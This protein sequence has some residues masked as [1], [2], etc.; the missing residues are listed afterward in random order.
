M[1]EKCEVN[2]GHADMVIETGR[3]A[4]Q[5][6]G[7]V[8]VQ[9]GGT[10]VLATVCSSDPREGINFFPLTVDYREKQYA[11]GKIPGNFFRREAR[12]SEKEILTCR[13]IDRPV[14]PLFPKG[15]KDEVQIMLAVISADK[16]NDPAI[17]A[18][19]GAMAALLLSDLPFTTPLAAVRVGRM[20]GK[21]VVNP[22]LDDL[23]TSELDLIIAGSADGIVMVEGGATGVP[24]DVVVDALAFGHDHVKTII[25]SMEGLAQRAGKTKVDVEPPAEPE[26]AADVRA[27]AESELKNRVLRI[28]DKHERQDATSEL[29]DKIQAELAERYPDAE[30]NIK[31][32]FHECESAVMRRITTEEKRRVDGRALDEVRPITIEVGLLPNAHGS[33][34][35]TRGETQALVAVTLGTSRDEQRLDELQSEPFKKFKSFMLHYN[36]PSFSVGEVRPNRGPGRREIGHGA[37][38]ER[39]LRPLMPEKEDFPYTVRIV[40]DIMESN[41]SSSMASVC[42]GSLSMMDGGVP[43]SK[44]VAGIAMGLIKEDG[45]TSILTD[46]LGLEDHLGDMDFK[47]TG[48]DEGITALQMDIKIGGVTKELLTEALAQAREGRLHILNEMNKTIAEHRPDL[49]PF[50]PRIVQMTISKEKIRDLIGPGGKVIRGICADTGAE[51]NVDDDGSV[52]VS[53]SDAASLEAARKMVEDVTAEAEVGKIY[54]GKV[55]R[56]VDFGAFVEILPGKDGLVRIGELADYHVNRVE[57]IVKEGDAIKVKCI[58]IDNMNRINLSKIEAERDLGLAPPKKEGDRR[59]R[60]KRGG[61]KSRGGRG[62]RRR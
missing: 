29:C 33:A 19:N 6:H 13:L 16:E 56:V 14:R 18:M 5:A 53:S 22:T 44:P 25:G 43:I 47:V 36:F 60:S 55:Q 41:G 57:D 46:I 10:M 8:T 15:Y 24:E 48:T 27:M 37:L 4:R 38:A 39:A 61:G 21:F 40:S 28:A 35:F 12:P 59:R 20:D 58:E 2:L 3:M 54:D 62:G 17:P 31:S 26:C 30:N 11:A 34:L 50:A 49:S 42:G 1:I 52:S 45:K 9:Y 7:S 23:E 51:I 32:V